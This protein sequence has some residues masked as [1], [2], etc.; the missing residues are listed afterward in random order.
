MSQQGWEGQQ[1]HR[2]YPQGYLDRS[3]QGAT[4]AGTG[5]GEAQAFLGSFQ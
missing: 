3:I 1:Q 4:E 5:W 2:G